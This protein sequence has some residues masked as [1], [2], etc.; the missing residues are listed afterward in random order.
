MDKKKKLLVFG[1][2]AFIIIWIGA[3][4]W[5]NLT[6]KSQGDSANRRVAVYTVP[7]PKKVFGEGQFRY[8]NEVSFTPDASK[9]TVNKIYVKD[10]QNVNKGQVLFDY[11]NEQVIQQCQELEKELAALSAVVEGVDPAQQQEQASAIARQLAD[12]KG[13]RYKNVTAPFAGVVAIP[14]HSE[15]NTEVIMRVVDSKLQL[16][17]SI[18]E[19]D[20]LKVEL[21][22]KVTISLYGNNRE[23]EG[24]I[25]FVGNEP[26]SA[27]GED[28]SKVMV[29]SLSNYPVYAEIDAEQ[30][31]G[32]YPGFHAQI[33]VTPSDEAPRIPKTAVFDSNGQTFVWKVVDDKIYRAQITYSRW[34]D[35]Y[36]NVLSGLEYGDRV[37]RQAAGEFKEGEKIAADSAED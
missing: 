8:R 4:F 26:V 15:G 7:A 3:V 10:G 36:L 30:Q 34:N 12:L 25:T 23:I 37:V 17:A 2:I 28:A 24:K 14:S 11:R 27:G 31:D 16:V 13:E 6:Q 1:V 21:G 19:R 22:Q 33:E 32:I 20:R 5:A 18:S 35:K 9:G 29:N